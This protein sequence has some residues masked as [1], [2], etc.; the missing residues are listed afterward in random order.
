MKLSII[1]VNYNVKY[2][3]EQCLHSVQKACKGLAAEVFVVDNNSVDGSNEM[4]RQKFPDVK[5]IANTIN[6]GFSKANNQAIH[7]SSGEFVLLLNPDTVV[8]EDTFRKILQFMD[9]HPDAGGLGVRMID[10]RG[11]FLPE[12]K[13]GLPTPLVA[14]YKMSGLSSL[15]P[16]SKVFGR[17][18]LGYLDE[19]EVAE[20]DVLAGAF[21]LL[22]RSVLDKTGLLD[23]EFFMY[24][25]DIDLSY[26]IT[27]AGYKNYYFPGTRIIHY[28]GESTK[29]SSVNYV[30]VFYNAMIIFAKKHFSPGHAS[31]FAILIKIAIYLRAGLAI[32]VQ[33]MK[34]MLLPTVDFIIMYAGFYF[35]KEYWAG[36]MDIHYPSEY[37]LI[38]VP[39]YIL[40]WIVSMFF[41][42]AYDPPVQLRKVV[43]GIFSGTLIILVIYALLPEAY[44]FS[45]VL[46]LLGAIWASVAAV[47]FRVLAGM[48]FGKYFTLAGETKKRL[49]IVGNEEEG[50]RVLSLLKISD[51]SHNFIGFV[52][53]EQVSTSSNERLAVDFSKYFLGAATNLSDIIEVYSIDEIIFCGKDVSSNQIMNSMS[54]TASRHV[55]YKIAPPESLFII[56]SSSVDNP[57]ELY[58]IDIN[59]IHRP[60][61][62]RNKRLLDILL[63]LGFIILLPLLLLI[64]RKPLGLIRNIVFVLIGRRSWVG[65]SGHSD[66]N[67]NLPK[68][69]AGIITPSQG[70]KQN[71]NSETLSR[72]NSLYAKDYS[73]Y[74]DLE[75]VRK[76][77]RNLGNF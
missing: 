30:F 6:T 17:Y 75:L 59:S 52:K 42:G 67:I 51:T 66:I 58:V 39:A 64:V 63:S 49:L 15:F 31:T 35:I 28:K 38:T 41:S 21:M 1:I 29:K 26:R 13:R 71:L 44:R 62:K 65:Y 25:E 50:S 45:R 16:G 61:N 43:R 47:S 11:K 27:K 5:L 77:W 70:L 8:E 55:D 3:L 2:F 76:G 40:L 9:E 10:G 53:P 60:V 23:E 56:G 69:R 14:F 36:K 33:F 72:L 7:E 46:I 48:I 57:G 54:M 12:S 73:V 20:V 37:M 34:K 74:K 18:H 68:I 4:V 22:R 32:V 24:G 19:H